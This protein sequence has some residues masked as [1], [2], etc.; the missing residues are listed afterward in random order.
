MTV[1][2]SVQMLSQPCALQFADRLAGRRH[3]L[4]DNSSCCCTDYF[5]HI[6][7]LTT[8]KLATSTS[9][10]VWTSHL[11][12]P[13]SLSPTMEKRAGPAK[14]HLRTKATSS[15]SRAWWTPRRT[16]G[17]SSTE[18]G[19]TRLRGRRGRRG[20]DGVFGTSWDKSADF[21]IVVI[22]QQGTKSAVQ[23]INSLARNQECQPFCRMT[24]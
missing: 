9:P 21:Q 4:N 15:A 7:R 6:M 22:N 8:W 19:A 13:P 14:H 17:R 10:F 11:D 3:C 12:D 20:A 24:R 1:S 5:A 2:V 18:S 23:Q 16:S